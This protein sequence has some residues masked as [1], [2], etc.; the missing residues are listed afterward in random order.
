MEIF[1]LFGNTQNTCTQLKNGKKSRQVTSQNIL[2]DE[3]KP[4]RRSDNSINLLIQQSM[5]RLWV[6]EV[7]RVYGD[8][9]VDEGDTSW[10][11]EQIR[12]TL[13]ER[14]DEDID[15]LFADFAEP[16]G[17]RIT[18]THLR[19]LIYCDFQRPNDDRKLYTEVTSLDDLAMVVQDFLNEYN[20]ISKK[21]MN[22]VLFRFAIEHLS[23][24]CRIMMQPRSHALLV[25]VGGSGRQSLTR[26]AS[27]I[28]D[29]EIFQVEI[30]RQYGVYEWREDLKIILRKSASSDLHTTFLFTDMQIKEESFL[31]DISNLMNSGEVPNLFAT[32]DK[33]EICEKMRQIDRQRD[34]SMQ[35]D[36]SPVALFNFFVQVVRDQLH[37]VV[38]MSPIGESFRT[39]IRKFPA[40]VNCCTIDWL[41]PWPE[42]ALLAV[43]TKFLG[44]IDLPDGERDAC[45]EMCQYFHTS[46]Q[47]LSREFFQRVGR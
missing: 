28:A 27:H 44:E 10:L 37:I 6:H 15:Q 33:T 2:S 7:L 22:L 29:H 47:E 40:L 20:S 12:S 39:R 5:K 1:P 23:K 30:A 25:G 3:K 13:S 36:G 19:N 45:I 16:H 35:T 42:D 38:A 18:E 9:L 21:P 34:K 32:D 11:V 17:A 41:Q 14:L 31:E 43:A 24:I 26:L 4:N 8:R 46:T